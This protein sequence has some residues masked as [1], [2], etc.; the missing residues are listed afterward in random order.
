MVVTH[1]KKWNGET[2][3]YLKKDASAKTSVPTATS[4]LS[5][6]LRRFS[7]K[8]PVLIKSPTKPAT[9]N[10]PGILPSTTL[11]PSTLSI[12]TSNKTKPSGILPPTS[13]SS[14]T[15][16]QQPQQPTT[17][18]QQPLQDLREQTTVPMDLSGEPSADTLIDPIE[19]SHEARRAKPLAAPTEPTSQE[20]QEHNLTHL[21]Y[22]TWCQVCVEAKGKLHQ[23]PR[24]T[25]KQPVV[26]IDY[27][28]LGLEGDEQRKLTLLCIVDTTSAVSYTHLTLPTS[29]LV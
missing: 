9:S 29:D 22:R 23:H 26:Q 10:K 21:P 18:I 12:T 4:E 7:S 28:F 2:H 25:S 13:T 8:K 16:S 1:L 3:F 17:S 11:K 6:T 24:L 15:T 14:E 5:R 27:G 19:P 20:R